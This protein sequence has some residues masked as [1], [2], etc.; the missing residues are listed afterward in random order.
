VGIDLGTTNS[1]IAVAIDGGA[2]LVIPN[3]QGSLTTPSVVAF[4]PAAGGPPFVGDE[5]RRQG[6]ASPEDTIYGVK[7]LI[8]RR[9]DD[10]EVKRHRLDATYEVTAGPH[11]EAWVKAGGAGRAPAEISALVLAALKRAAEDQLGQAVT[12]AVIG[13]PAYFDDAQRQATRTAGELAGLR[14]LRL[15]NEPTAA[16]LAYDAIAAGPDG[17]GEENVAVYDLG[18]G[19][20]D[21][22][23][24]RLRDGEVEVCATG[25]DSFLG[26]DDF[27]Q[28]IVTELG[29]RF[30]GQH[31]IDPR[32]DPVARRRLRE[33]AQSAKHALSDSEAVEINLPFL[34]AGEPRANSPAHLMTMLTRERFETLTRD[35]VDRTI[36]ACE[37]ALADAGWQA[38][39]VDRVLLIGGQTRMPALRAQVAALFGGG[40]PCPDED[41]AHPAVSPDQGV[42]LGAAYLGASLRGLLP[43]R[44]LVE[45]I[46]VSVGV[47][48]AGGVFTRI[49][50]RHTPL[51]AA[52]A[53][54]FS[55]VSDNQPQLTIHVLQGERELAADNKSVGHF[56]INDI[57]PAPKGVPQIEVALQ[58]DE[59]GLVDVSAMNLDTGQKQAVETAQPAPQGG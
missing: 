31:Q 9:L 44:K 35:L 26:G 28:R 59:N 13:V 51:P 16:V 7:R 20:F 39:D 6:T 43:D 36:F 5:A 19:T 8:G 46:S 15:L 29:D 3:A 55:T 34:M 30:Q 50:P 45:R 54:I 27:D 23:L 58:I 38:A 22:S 25:G 57:P 37:A 2:P 33:A 17:R 49:V 18:G 12:D 52:R 4:G 11:G 10:P 1:C 40:E 42:A 32:S 48:T 41:P 56:R 47:E 53:Q 24:L 21:V 14:V